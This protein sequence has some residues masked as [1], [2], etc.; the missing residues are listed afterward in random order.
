MSPDQAKR[1]FKENGIRYVLA[2]F[3]DLHGAAKAKAVPVE[4]YDM[5]VGDGAG[6]AGFAVWGLG[7]GPHG[8][9]FMGVGDPSTIVNIPWMPGFA[10]MA[11]NGHVNGK[12]YSYCSRVA[13]QTQ[14]QRFTERGYTLNTGIE[15]EFML[16]KR[17]ASGTLKPF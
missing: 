12:A 8:P 9:D 4:H 7:M 16:L 15:P 1:F 2:Q 13:A 5:I 14:L 3:V 6:F 17:D 11:C 10:R